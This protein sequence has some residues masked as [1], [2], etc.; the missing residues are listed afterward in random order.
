MSFFNEEWL[1]VFSGICKW[2]SGYLDE[3]DGAKF[4]PFSSIK[5]ELHAVDCLL[6]QASESAK[7]PQ[8]SEYTCI[9]TKVRCFVGY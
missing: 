3:L 5:D 4:I 1:L 8:N 6:S 9:W 7:C 2:D